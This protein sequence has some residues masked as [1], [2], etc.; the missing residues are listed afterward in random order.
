[1]RL[2]STLCL[3][4]ALTFF[5]ASTL[6]VQAYDRTINFSG[7]DWNVKS[8]YNGPGPNYWN[9]SDEAVFTDS[10]GQL[11]MKI[12]NVD[13]SWYSSEVYLPS[14]LGYGTYTFTLL[15]NPNQIDTNI[16]LAP[17][18]YQDDEHEID[19]EYTDWRY[20]GA[21]NINYTVQ[22]YTLSG[23]TKTFPSP[24]S[25]SSS[26][27]IA[28]ITWAPEKIYFE[29]LQDDRLIADWKYVGA[30]NFQPGSERVHINFWMIKGIAPSDSSQ[31]EAVIR[32]FSFTPYS[33]TPMYVTAPE[34]T[35]VI[36]TPK[37]K[38]IKPDHKKK[39]KHQ[40]KKKHGKYYT[41]HY[42]FFSKTQ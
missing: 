17:F 40:R 3:T 29:T 14:S 34:P 12:T 31:Q 25:Y 32:S 39:K 8:G 42:K 37:E 41:K 28:R 35:N 7:Y 38:K 18:L 22:P 9:D 19:I 10:E 4:I 24:T 26:P 1:M 30:N 11:H 33:N 20:E 15:T 21:D 5:I 36:I 6:S 16:V 23:N 27:I 2:K 13:N